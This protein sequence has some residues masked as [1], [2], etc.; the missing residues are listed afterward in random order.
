LALLIPEIPGKR[1][2]QP[3]DILTQSP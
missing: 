1:R 2:V 3:D